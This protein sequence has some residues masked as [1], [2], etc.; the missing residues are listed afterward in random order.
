M[1]AKWRKYM[2]K[3]PT[4][5]SQKVF[6][7]IGIILCVILIPMLILNITLI[8]KSSINSDEVPNVGGYLPMIVLTDSM[9]PTINSGDLI[10]CCTIDA[11]VVKKDDIISFIDPSGNGTSIVTHRVIEV[12]NED[13]KL[14]FR[15]KGDKNNTEDRKLVPAENLVGIY[16]TRFAGLGNVAMF[17][18]SP[19]GIIVCV[20]LPIA[21]LV[22][23][24]V[25]RRR[26]YEKRN[27]TDTDA[28]L[29]EI[30]ELKAEKAK[31]AEVTEEHTEVSEEKAEVSED[32][33]EETAA[34]DK[35]TDEF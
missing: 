31:K 3:E 9:E 27:Q 34:V 24:E 29:A 26:M 11:E 23:Y 22:G 14:Y 19:M 10:F 13:G 4:S 35:Q 1:M 5:I 7:V 15:T 33:T 2:N 8:I 16:K 32:K 20:I 25:I 12:V 6:S 28:L 17:M 30:A 18:Q 21:L